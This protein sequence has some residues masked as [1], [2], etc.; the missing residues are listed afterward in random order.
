MDE[1]RPDRHRAGVESGLGFGRQ[2]AAD[3]RGFFPPREDF[4]KDVQGFGR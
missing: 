3:V 2:P 4:A 1:P